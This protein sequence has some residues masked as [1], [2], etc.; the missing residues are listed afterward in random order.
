MEA[1]VIDM[2]EAAF[3]AI[4]D[5]L[6]DWAS[7]EDVVWK[8]QSWI[9]G[10]R[11][12]QTHALVVDR[13]REEVSLLRLWKGEGAP[14]SDSQDFAK[15]FADMKGE[16]DEMSFP[17][18]GDADEDTLA[19][20]LEAAFR[21]EVGGDVVFLWKY[22]YLGDGSYVARVARVGHDEALVCGTAARGSDGSISAKVDFSAPLDELLP[23][24]RLSARR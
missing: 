8:D 24:A 19:G 17:H 4:D 1:E 16:I 10:E 2:E 5:K 23:T 9:D 22:D 6:A 13:E 3:A 14:V 15:S 12:A 11:Y 18:S 21:D 7:I 20:E